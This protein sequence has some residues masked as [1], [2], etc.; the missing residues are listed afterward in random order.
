MRGVVTLS[1]IMP[2]L[3]GNTGE[4]DGTESAKDPSRCSLDHGNPL[5]QL[6][7]AAPA[8]E[9]HLVI[10]VM[11]SLTAHLRRVS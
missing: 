7:E 2:D 4:H 10:G 5:H 8:S 9:E 1:A 11:A 3:H 6:S